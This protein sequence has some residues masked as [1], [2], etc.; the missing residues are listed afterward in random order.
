[1]FK[2]IISLVLTLMVLASMAAIAVPATSAA[3]DTTI[4]FQVPDSWNNYK[5][6]FC[7]I[8][9]YGGD[10]LAGWQVKASKCTQVEGQEKLYSYDISKV[11]GLQAGQ[12]YGVIFSVNTGLQTYDTLLSTA[13]YG[14]TVYCDG[15]TFENPADSNKT[16]TAAYWKNQNRSTY[17][18]IMGIT[19][20]GNVVGNCIAP[21]ETAEGLMT[22]FLGGPNLLSAQA[23]SGKDDQTLI[24]DIANVLG[25]SQDQVEA[26][27]KETGAQVKW[28]KAESKA[29]EVEKPISPDAGGA[30]GTGQEMTIVYIASAMM[31]AAAGVI[32]FA[33]KKRIAE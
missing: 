30:V 8:W 32:F 27:I 12:L 26:I 10:S 15:T 3:E 33:R 9:I 23:S 28:T 25:L 1:M 19:S 31:I 6:V 24:D 11:G 16:A 13:C 2:K 5:S 29:P 22:K 17:G 7:H 20:I 4:Y 14:D 21:G 18:P